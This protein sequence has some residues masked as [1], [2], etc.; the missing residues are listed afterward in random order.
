A[1]NADL[2]AQIQ[3]KVFAIT[4]LKNDLRKLKGNGVDTKFANTSVLGK[5]VLQPLRNKSVVRQPNA[6][7]HKRPPISNDMV[8][9][10]YLDEAKK[11]TRERD[12]NSKPS[13]MTS[14]RLQSTTSTLGEIVSLEK[15]NKNVIGQRILTSYQSN[16]KG[17]EGIYYKEV[18][19]PVAR[20]E[21]IRLFLAYASFM[22][23]IVYQMGV[24]SVFLYGTI[25]EEVYVIQPPRFQDLKF[26]E[27]VYKVKK[28]MYGLHQAPRAWYGTLSKYLLDNGFQRGT[29]DHTLF[30]R[31]HKGEF[32]LVQVY[33]DDIIFGSSNPQLCR[34]FEALMHDKFQMSAMGELTFFLGL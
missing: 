18:F 20:I 10:H 33:V 32:L 21:A 24:K 9:N 13:V 16:P 25:D 7:K 2:K 5:P 31:K 15:S 27:R 30:I 22:G 1:N 23:F 6:F 28:A 26:P 14:A 12:K 17:E 4:A 11:K 3:E 19:A 29:I 8:H 34:E